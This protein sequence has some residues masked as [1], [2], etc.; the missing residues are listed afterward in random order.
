M[1]WRYAW[2][3]GLLSKRSHL[4]TAGNPKQAFRT[5]SSAQLA[6]ASLELKTG[7]RFDVYRCWVYCRKFH[8]GGSVR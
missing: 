3:R 2:V 7:R 1:R 4:T 5:R 8:I 6:A